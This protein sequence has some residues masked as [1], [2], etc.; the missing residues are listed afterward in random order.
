M[1]AELL[2]KVGRLAFDKAAPEGE[3]QAAAIKMVFVARRMGLDFDGFKQTLGIQD[4]P[5]SSHSEPKPKPEQEQKKSSCPILHFGK[6]KGRSVDW[7]INRN[8]DYLIWCLKNMEDPPA[9]IRYAEKILKQ[10]GML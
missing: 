2:Q 5:H 7:V 10:K 9:S 6:F 4:Q 3:A 1:S 8:P